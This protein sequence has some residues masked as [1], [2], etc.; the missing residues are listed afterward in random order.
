MLNHSKLGNSGTIT[1][2][3][4]WWQNWVAWSRRDE[5]VSRTKRWACTEN[6]KHTKHRFPQQTS[7]LTDDCL[8]LKVKIMFKGS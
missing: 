6:G 8:N 4:A 7:F 3:K 5:E 2:E 1:I